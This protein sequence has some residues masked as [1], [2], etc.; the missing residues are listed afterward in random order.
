MNSIGLTIHVSNHNAGSV[1]DF[2]IFPQNKAFYRIRTV[3]RTKTL[4]F[5]MLACMEKGMVHCGRYS[6]KMATKSQL[7][8]FV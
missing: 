7:K 4:R 1:S 8:Y 5:A 6:W 3:K 2:E